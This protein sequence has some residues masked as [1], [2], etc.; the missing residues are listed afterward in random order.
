MEIPIQISSSVTFFSVS[1]E[2]SSMEI[3]FSILFVNDN[4]KVSGEL[5]SMEMKRRG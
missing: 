3:K 5:S 2:L 1:G 4:D